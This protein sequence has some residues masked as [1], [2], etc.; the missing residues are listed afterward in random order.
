[1]SKIEQLPDINWSPEAA[2]AHIQEMAGDIDELFIIYRS[3][4][5]GKLYSAAANM[6]TKDAFWMLEYEK[7]RLIK[8]VTEEQEEI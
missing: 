4:E 7:A 5:D 1:M 3:K 6:N 8:L 2:L